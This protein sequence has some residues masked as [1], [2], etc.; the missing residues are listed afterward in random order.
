[1]CVLGTCCA[2]GWAWIFAACHRN[3]Q[4]HLSDAPSEHC[5]YFCSLSLS[6]VKCSWFTGCC[7]GHSQVSI[8]CGMHSL[9][10]LGFSC[11]REECSGLWQEL[12]QLGLFQVPWLLFPLAPISGTLL[13]HHSGVNQEHTSS[14]CGASLTMW[15]PNIHT[16]VGRRVGWGAVTGWRCMC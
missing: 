16:S 8:P 6:R 14:W 9:H 13:A 4:Q 7:L 3:C 12:E 15:A 2:S 1:M 11:S 10:L 5:T